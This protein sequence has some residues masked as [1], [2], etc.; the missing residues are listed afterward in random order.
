MRA[1]PR[2]TVKRGAADLALLLAIGLF[3]GTVGPYGTDGLPPRQVYVYWLLCIVGG[4]LI[5]VAVD[6]TIGR[7][8][9]GFWR[10][11][12]ATTVLMTPPTTLLVMAA[13][14]VVAGGALSLARYWPLLWQ[15][16]LISIPVMAIRALVWRRPPPVVET[17]V[18][19]TPPLP[20]AEAAFRRRLSARRRAARLIA[21]EADDHYLRV[22]TDAG[23]EMITLRLAVA[24]DELSGAHGFQT[25]RSWWVAA[26]AIEGARWRRGGGELRLAGGLTAPV[27]RSHAA[28]VKAAGWF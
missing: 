20:E 11:L 13:G 9:P 14:H 26:E 7:R 23:S 12:L 6:E 27:S 5:G 3:M 25:H 15:V 1:D 19:V 16:F 22:H 8:A 10:R 2:A 18:V 21:I 4:G 24:L 17:R 28:T